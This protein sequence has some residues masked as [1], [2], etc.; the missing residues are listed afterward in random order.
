[1]IPGLE[2]L[3]NPTALTILW[4]V[5][6]AWS[7]F[8]KGIALWK[9]AIEKQKIWFVALLFIN[10]LGLLEI[11]YLFSFSKK[12]MTLQELRGYFSRDNFKKAK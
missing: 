9:S 6:M 1:M 4:F 3:N 11:I 2:F 10:S 5:A 12:K 8:W 7:F